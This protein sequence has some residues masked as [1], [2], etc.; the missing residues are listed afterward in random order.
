MRKMT[1]RQ[2]VVRSI[3]IVGISCIVILI[4]LWIM[5]NGMLSTYRHHGVEFTI[6]LA[7]TLGGYMGIAYVWENSKK[8]NERKKGLQ[9]RPFSMGKYLS[10]ILECSLVFKSNF[11][12]NIISLSCQKVV[13]TE[14]GRE[15]IVFNIGDTVL[16]LVDMLIAEKEKN[17]QLQQQIQQDTQKVNEDKTDT[18]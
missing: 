4:G 17:F 13:F 16:R 9:F 1:A 11:L 3:V 14:G 10:I 7:I 6:G 18:D 5:F 15:V 12:Q 2:K 8:N